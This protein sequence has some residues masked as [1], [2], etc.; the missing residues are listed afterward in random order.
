MREF[1]ISVE[2][3]AY[4]VIVEE[5]TDGVAP[6]SVGITSPPPAP[7]S[8]TVSRAAVP[9]MSATPATAAPGDVLSSLAGTITAVEVKVGDTVKT[10]D[11]LV[12]LEAMKMNTPVVAPA[13]GTV[14]SVAVVTGDSVAE[15]QILLSIG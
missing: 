5:L 12:M 9:Q 4:N 10:G 7:A 2:G 6:Q 11:V 1:R 3:V 14:R 15:G 8:S 13:P